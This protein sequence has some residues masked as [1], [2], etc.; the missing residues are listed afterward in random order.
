MPRGMVNVGDAFEP[1]SVP[2]MN[3]DH[4]NDIY[5][6]ARGGQAAGA[7]REVQGLLRERYRLREGRPDDF[8]IQ[9][10][11]EVLAADASTARSFT[12]LLAAVSAVALLIG[13]VGVLAV[14]LIAVRERTREVG[15]RRAIGATRPEILLQFGGEAFAIGIVG[16]VV[17][18][19][20]GSAVALLASAVG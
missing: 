13:G 1:G 15:L 7:F 10:Q 4:I 11:A 17:G 12:V 9:N 2:A 20:V 6:Q 3:L 8:T 14:M 19:V 5:V 16:G 18:L